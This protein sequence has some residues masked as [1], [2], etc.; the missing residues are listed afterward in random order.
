M[1][2]EIDN[3]NVIIEFMSRK[4]NTIHLSKALSKCVA[5]IEFEGLNLEKLQLC[6]TDVLFEHSYNNTLKIPALQPPYYS[7]FWTTKQHFH[8]VGNA[9]VIEGVS[10]VGAA[11]KV[12]V[13]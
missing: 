10:P 7:E 3:I 9:M 12:K 8:M 6:D 11:Y 13:W 5:N 4:S 1:D 2:K